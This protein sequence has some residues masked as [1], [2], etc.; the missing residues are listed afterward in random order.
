[1]IIKR[2]DWSFALAIYGAG[3][4][5]C[6]LAPHLPERL[7][8]F[9]V[10][11]SRLELTLGDCTPII[12]EDGF[13]TG[14]KYNY[15]NLELNC[16]LFRSNLIANCSNIILATVQGSTESLLWRWSNKPAILPQ[17]N[18]EIMHSELFQGADNNW[19]VGVPLDMF[20]HDL[21]CDEANVVVLQNLS[22]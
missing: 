12:S 7:H 1:M 18:G 17:G 4:A 16:D 10:S 14:V 21:W 8:I 19:A 20:K 9:N 15:L 13:A 3:R 11:Y 6:V 5:R 2:T 22:D